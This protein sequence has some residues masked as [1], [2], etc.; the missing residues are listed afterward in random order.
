MFA[1]VTYIRGE[2]LD[3]VIVPLYHSHETHQAKRKE[4][5]NGTDCDFDRLLEKAP[6]LA[7]HRDNPSE[8]ESRHNKK[9]PTFVSLQFS[10]PAVSSRRTGRNYSGAEMSITLL[11]RITWYRVRAMAFAGSCAVAPGPEARFI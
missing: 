3:R 11:G 5:S 10:H 1:A 4:S 8:R 6:L 2:T 9:T 7:S